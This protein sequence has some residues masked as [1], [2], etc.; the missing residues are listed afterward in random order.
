MLAKWMAA[1]LALLALAARPGKADTYYVNGGC[2][3]DAWSGLSA[4]CAD[5][6]GMDGPK[7]TI[8][9]AVDAAAPG[10]L[11]VVAD[12]VYTGDGNGDIDFGGKAITV[13]SANGPAQCVIDCQGS[14]SD[15][16]R[17]FHFHSGEL[18]DSQVVGFTIQGGYAL[19]G[20]GILCDDSSPTLSKIILS[21]NVGEY[22][23]GAIACYGSSPAIVNCLI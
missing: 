8:Q 5:P 16:H 4:D 15:P 7:A 23:G 13:R 6:N 3:N 1:C 19:A 12:G 10:D 11:V 21:G 18:S 17:A 14:E 9:A 20:G 22:G 2:G